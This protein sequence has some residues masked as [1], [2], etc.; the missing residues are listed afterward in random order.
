MRYLILLFLL[1]FILNAQ[2][3]KIATAHWSPYASKTDSGEYKGIAV[4]IAQTVIIRAGHTYTTTLYPT[5]RLKKLFQYEKI[6]I[7]FADS[8]LWNT[9]QKNSY[10]TKPY[11]EVKEF[12]YLLKKIPQR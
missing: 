1:P 2:E 3:F 6:D 8:P 9:D 10:F 4:D 12:L 7:N 5:N 11:L